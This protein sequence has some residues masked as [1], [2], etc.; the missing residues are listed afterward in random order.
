LTADLIADLTADLTAD[1]EVSEPRTEAATVD[2]VA[3]ERP[4]H[5]NEFARC[6][7][8][9]ATQT[10]TLAGVPFEHAATDTA[11]LRTIESFHRTQ[12]ERVRALVP[13]QFEV[14]LEEFSG[15]IDAGQT[16]TALELL[17]S[18]RAFD[19]WA[20]WW[21]AVAQDTITKTAE[22]ETSETLHDAGYA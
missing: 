9:H 13:A 16:M 4:L 2:A 21:F 7:Q 12:V 11:G 19:S 20:S 22:P 17:A 5:F 15:A 10:S 18:M 14:S 8:A 1:V 6:A 3:E